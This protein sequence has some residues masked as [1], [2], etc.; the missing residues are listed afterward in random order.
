MKQALVTSDKYKTSC[1]EYNE[2]EYHMCKEE[3]PSKPSGKNVKKVFFVKFNPQ[4]SMGILQ[5]HKFHIS[6][7]SRKL[8]GF[9]LWAGSTWVKGQLWPVKDSPTIHL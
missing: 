4:T 3:L 6:R 1:I 7:L 8:P 9:F 5:T 2:Y